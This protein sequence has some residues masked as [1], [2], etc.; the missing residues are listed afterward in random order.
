MFPPDDM[1]PGKPVARDANGLPNPPNPA[2]PPGVGI[3]GAATTCPG[4]D[5]HP[6]EPGDICGGNDGIL[7]W[8]AAIAGSTFRNGWNVE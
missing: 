2:M 4:L 1:M 7:V 3:S 5:L 8:N 6:D